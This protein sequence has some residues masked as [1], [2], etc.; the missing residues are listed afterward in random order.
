MSEI[1]K[2]ILNRWRTR[3]LFNKRVYQGK[4]RWM[5]NKGSFKN[6]FNMSNPYL[7][8][9]L[10]PLCLELFYIQIVDGIPYFHI[11]FVFMI[12]NITSYWPATSLLSSF[13]IDQQN[14]ALEAATITLCYFTC[15][16]AE[17][18]VRSLM[19][20]FFTVDRSFHIPVL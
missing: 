2:V 16:G 9:C 15:S 17:R 14:R 1:A 7:I 12:L 13:F 4:E 3:S 20:K 18:N 11:V 6:H 8:V 5:T 10:F 19:T